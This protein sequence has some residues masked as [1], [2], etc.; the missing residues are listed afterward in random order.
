MLKYMYLFLVVLAGCSDQLLTKHSIE[1]KYVY[2][3]YYNVYVETDTAIIEVPIEDTAEEPIW[4][5]SFVQPT[6]SDG[7]DIIWVIDP[8][9]SMISHKPRVLT[10]IE[11]MINALPLNISWRLAII[12]A[13]QNHS[14]NDMTFPLLP[15]DTVADAQA[16]YQNSVTGGYEA[17]FW[18]VYRYI[19]ENPFA[20]NWL[21]DEAA[22]LVVFVS[23][24]EEQ[25]TSTFPLVNDFT[26]W[27]D[28]QRQGVFV[29]SIA[30]SY[31]HLKLPTTPYE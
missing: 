9:G 11:D 10:G 19:E 21:R 2:P 5:D 28:E 18:S 7:V 15:G 30:V 3:S 17:G 29:A 14:V 16:M 12:S 22:L 4:V 13:D 8:S 20:A 24:E 23:D 31:T 26:S 25:G 27:L 1:E 6:S